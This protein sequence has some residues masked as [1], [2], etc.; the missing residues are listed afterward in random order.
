MNDYSETAHPRILDALVRT[1][2]VQHLGYGLD[3]IC[4]DACK[5]IR[6]ECGKPN[7]TVYFVS[8]GTQA[9]LITILS[10]LR[11]W[12]AVIATHLGHIAVSEAGAIEAGGHKIITAH[13][14]DGK[15]K[16]HDID[17]IVAKRVNSDYVEQ[18]KLVY[19]SN[20]T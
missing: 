3:P 12:E 8:G 18:P 17:H 19:I 11:P 4:V 14:E 15:L 1:N 2:N 13:C 5:L 20:T 16:P 10:I 6:E 9:N 7:A